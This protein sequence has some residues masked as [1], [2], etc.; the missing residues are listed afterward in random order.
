MTFSCSDGGKGWHVFYHFV[1]AVP[2]S[3]DVLQLMQRLLF[4]VG[5]EVGYTTTHHPVS[6]SS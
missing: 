2:G 3:T 1:G 6:R 4:E 5:I